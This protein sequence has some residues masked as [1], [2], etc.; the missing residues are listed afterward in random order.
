V[1]IVVKSF[2]HEG[3]QRIHIGTFRKKENNYKNK[4][5]YEI[6]IRIKSYPL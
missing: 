5:D 6:S 2:N 3:K 4:D 1:G